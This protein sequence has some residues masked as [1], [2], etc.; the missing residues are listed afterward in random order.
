MGFLFYALFIVSLANAATLRATLVEPSALGNVCN[1]GTG[2]V[3][4]FPFAPFSSSPPSVDVCRFFVELEAGEELRAVEALVIE[5]NGPFFRSPFVGAEPPLA[6]LS[7]PE[8]PCSTFVAMGLLEKSGGDTVDCT[9]LAP[10]FEL[11]TD[12]ISGAW[13]CNNVAV[14][15]VVTNG[16]DAKS[17]IVAQLSQENRVAQVSIRARFRVYLRGAAFSDLEATCLGRSFEG[18]TVATSLTSAST[19][20]TTTRTTTTFL[21]NGSTTF[22]GTTSPVVD[23]EADGSGRQS[24]AWI[25]G[26]VV[27]ALFL[28]ALVALIVIFA[29]RRRRQKQRQNVNLVGD[30]DIG[31][32]LDFESSPPAVLPPISLGTEDLGNEEFFDFL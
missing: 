28:V 9:G 8:V 23:G 29:K 2:V 11:G 7:S 3:L 32:S 4:T 30:S 18:P 24:Q 6:A 20:T 12:S 26:V 13:F 21:D 17:V 5:T 25:A 22:G 27:G 14:P 16:I 1:T 31:A 10:D 15:H 19:T